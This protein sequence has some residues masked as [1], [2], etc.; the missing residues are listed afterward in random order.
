[1][2]FLLDRSPA[3]CLNMEPLCELYDQG[4]LIDYMSYRYHKQRGYLDGYLTRLK[5]LEGE[6]RIEIVKIQRVLF[7]NLYHEGYSFVAWRPIR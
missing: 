7:G 4:N 3:L 1:M 6:S 2:Q 5:Q